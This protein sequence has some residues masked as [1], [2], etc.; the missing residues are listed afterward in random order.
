MNEYQ[1]HKEIQIRRKTHMI[2][3][4]MIS[5]LKL[6]NFIT[7]NFIYPLLTKYGNHIL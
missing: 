4:C 2:D 6:L 3:M 5:R 7:E 1:Y